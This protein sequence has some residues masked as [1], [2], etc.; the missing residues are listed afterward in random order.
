[1][2]SSVEIERVVGDVGG[3]AETAAIAVSPPEGGPS[4][5]VLFAVAGAGV[6][7]EVDEVRD[8]MAMAIAQHLNPLFKLHDVVVVDELP[9]TASAKVMRR[10]LRARYTE[11]G[12]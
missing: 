11:G 10:E 2:I 5:L 3:V 1:K 6:E 4:Q 7:L 8:E 12:S 9:R